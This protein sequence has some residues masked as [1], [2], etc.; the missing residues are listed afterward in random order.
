MTGTRRGRID[1]RRVR[2]AHLGLKRM[3]AEGMAVSG[4]PAY[5]WKEFSDAMLRHAIGDA[6][7]ELPDEDKNV[8]KLAYFGGWSNREISAAYGLTQTAVE[9]RLRRAIDRI[10]D[11]VH[12]GSAIVRRAALVVAAWFCARWCGG[13]IEH[14]GQA[15]AV[16]AA[17]AIIAVQPAGPGANAPAP[18]PPAPTHVMSAPLPGRVVGPVPSPTALAPAP[19]PAQ[20]QPGVPAPLQPAAVPVSIPVPPVPVPAPPPVSVPPAPISVPPLPPPPPLP[21]KPPL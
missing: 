13:W 10:S 4:E 17:A 21:V 5:T 11:H 14:V 3:L 1:R 18:A 16:A 20:T 15:S 19:Q 9:R 6:V 2:G 7:R 8:L 12:R